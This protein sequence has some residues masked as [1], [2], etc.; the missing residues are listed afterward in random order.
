MDDELMQ[1]FAWEDEVEATPNADEASLI[2][3]SPQIPNQFWT[4]RRGINQKDGW[5]VSSGVDFL[6]F[7]SRKNGKWLSLDA[8]DGHYM[9]ANRA[10][11]GP[12]EKFKP[13]F[14]GNN[15]IA[16]KGWNGKYISCNNKN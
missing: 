1:N 4:E 15:Q 2:K 3:T 6:V 7:K 10:Q 5:G 14:I 12:W 8:W 16:L 13:L 9:K 11:N